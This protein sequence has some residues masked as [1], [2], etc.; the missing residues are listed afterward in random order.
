KSG[1][2]ERN[3][4]SQSTSTRAIFTTAV[5]TLPAGTYNWRAKNPKYL[6]N[7]GTVTLTG[8]PITNLE[9]G[10]MRAG[11]ANNDNLIGAGDFNVLKNSYGR[12]IGDPGYDDRGDFN[13]EI[14]RASCREGEKE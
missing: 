7:S 6:A 1:T 12:G 13:G 11:D 5:G 10:T 2:L 9:M 14:G 3:Y 4:P 8:S